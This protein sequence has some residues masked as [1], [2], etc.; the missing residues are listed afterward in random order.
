[1]RSTGV[2]LVGLALIAGCSS[3]EARS[4]FALDAGGGDGAVEAADGDPSDAGPDADPT[5]GGPCLDDGQCDDHLDCTADRC[6]TTLGRCRFGPDDTLCQNGLYCDGR[7]VCDPKLGCR[8]GVPE[9]CDDLSACTID[10]CV[11]ATQTCEHATRDADGDGDPDA[12]CGGGHD[13]DDAD[14]SVSSLHPEVCANG[15]DDDC[16]GQLDEAPCTAPAHDTCTDPLEIQADGAYD[17]F[18]GAAALDYALSCTP[19][20]PGERDVVAAI[21]V[22]QGPARDVDVVAIAPAGSLAVGLAGACGKANS[23][24]SCMAGVVAPAFGT[25]ARIRGRALA[26]GNYPLYV[27]TDSDQDVTLHVS[28]LA[29]EPKPTNETCGTAAPLALG[30]QTTVTL[31]DPATDLA[32]NCGTSVGEL[33]YSFT[34]ASASDVH[35]YASS[36]DGY[37]TPSVSLRTAACATIDDEIGCATA[38]PLDLYERALPAGTYHVAVSATAPTV[39]TLDVEASPPTVAPADESCASPPLVAPNQT[40]PVSLAGHEDD[41]SL[42]ATGYVDAAYDLELAETSDV[43]LVERIASG[44]YGAVSLALP[45]CADADRLV[46]GNAAQSPVRASARKVPAGSYRAVVESLYGNDVTLTAFVRPYTPPTLVPFADT[47]ADAVTIPPEGGFFQGNTANASAD[48]SAGCDVGGQGPNGGPEQMLR[49]DLPQKKR[50]VFDMTGSTYVTVL[51]VRR[52]P[53]CPGTELPSS[54]SAGFAASRSYLDL[55]LAA[56]TYWVQIDGYGGDAGP[57]L[58]DVRV[59]DP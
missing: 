9:A 14:P 32:T 6:D 35:V 46:C 25:L 22:P 48:Y 54:C 40:M 2:V 26:S 41:V 50:V 8:P 5:L 13:C 43:L 4:P 12:H 36:I 57:W 1:M 38:E 11:E 10:T 24:L 20:L 56:G 49:L 18:T 33:V 27:W 51:D 59:V 42:C 15:K 30:Q 28:F 29:P 45:S 17:L 3:S 37:G 47:C 44:D 7:E 34:L 52:G 21:E 58:L 16:D 39:L 31:V 19:A 55:T 23:E 53:A